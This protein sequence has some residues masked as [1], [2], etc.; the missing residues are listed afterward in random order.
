MSTALSSLQ[1]NDDTR[2]LFDKQGEKEII[3]IFLVQLKNYRVLLNEAFGSHPQQ[4]KQIC[5]LS[6]G[7]LGNAIYFNVS[8]LLQAITEIIEASSKNVATENLLKNV[9]HEI[10][11]ILNGNL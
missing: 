3:S 1:L 2:A 10:D 7:L 6:E 5:F 11:I 8:N 4:Q 9:N